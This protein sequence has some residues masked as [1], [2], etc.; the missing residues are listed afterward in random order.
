MICTYLGLS[1][2]NGKIRLDTHS[3][4]MCKQ[5]DGSTVL[6][7]GQFS[8]K[9]LQRLLLAVGLSYQK[10]LIGLTSMIRLLI[11]SNFMTFLN[12]VII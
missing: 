4:D 3:T 1:F 8:I 5:F 9:A 6:G 2:A 10:L 11:H 7:L 12:A